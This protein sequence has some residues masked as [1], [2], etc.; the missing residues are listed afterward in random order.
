[1]ASTSTNVIV[2]WDIQGTSVRPNLTPVTPTLVRMRGTA[3]GGGKCSVA[4]RWQ[5]TTL[6]ATVPEGILVGRVTYDVSFGTILF[7]LSC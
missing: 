5:P 1:M 7:D 6:N 4:A 3:V 2:T